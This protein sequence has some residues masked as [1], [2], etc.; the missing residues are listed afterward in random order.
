M[1]DAFMTDLRLIF[2]RPDEVDLAVGAADLETVSGVD[3]LVQALTLRLLVDQG[4]LSGLGH[5]LYGSRIR[6]LVGETLDRANLELLRRYVRQTLLADPR[7]EEVNQ[8][9]TRLRQDALDT[10]EV[11]A[12]VTAVGGEQAELGVN[13]YVG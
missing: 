3:N 4:E 1:A 9:I 11:W 8:V 12:Q 10:V 7:V 13:V 2:P 5:P 6:E